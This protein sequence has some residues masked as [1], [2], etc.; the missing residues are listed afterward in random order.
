LKVPAAV[1]WQTE[2]VT[3][4][5][6][7]TISRELIETL[8]II[9]GNLHLLEGTSQAASSHVIQGSGKPQPQMQSISLVQSFT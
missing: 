6:A 8:Y 3:T 1:A 9:S 5:P 4:T 2:Q 7:L